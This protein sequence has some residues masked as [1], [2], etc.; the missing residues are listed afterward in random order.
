MSF[1]Y[2]APIFKEFGRKTAMSDPSLPR[3]M[4]S[5]LREECQGYEKLL[6]LSEEQ[7][8]LLRQDQPDID[9]AAAL[10]N[11]KI[12]LAG[13]LRVLEERNAPLKERWARDYTACPGE[14]RRAVAGMRDRTVA[15]IERL[16][17]LE[18]ETIE[19]LRECK[20]GVGRQLRAL[21]Q[22]RQAANAYFV[23]ERI[24]PRFIDKTQ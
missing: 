22:A 16:Q 6:E 1:L 23:T 11:Q 8:A 5:A 18:T 21:Q 13:E 20:A 15:V 14:E 9:R 24:P 17:A 12:Q 7:I 10:M 3:L 19:R 2:E 4:E